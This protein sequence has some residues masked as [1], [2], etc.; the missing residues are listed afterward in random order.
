[1]TA[2]PQDTTHCA[3]GGGGGQS[4]DDA[5][6]ARGR[7]FRVNTRAD[8]TPRNL[9]R[10]RDGKRDAQQREDTRK[11]ETEMRI[12]ANMRQGLWYHSPC[13]HHSLSLL[14]FLC[15]SML[16]NGVPEC[17]HLA[18]CNLVQVVHISRPFHAL[19]L[20]DWTHPPPAGFSSRKTDSLSCDHQ[21]LSSAVDFCSRTDLSWYCGAVPA[22]SQPLTRV[23]FSPNG[24]PSSYSQQGRNSCCHCVPSYPVP[25][26]VNHSERADSPLAYFSPL[27]KPSTAAPT[28]SQSTRLGKKRPSVAVLPRPITFRLRWSSQGSPN[29]NLLFPCIAEVVVV[30][31]HPNGLGALV[32][33]VANVSDSGGVVGCPAD[34]LVRSLLRRWNHE[35]SCL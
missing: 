11:G 35:D 2:A 28:T 20:L 31:R 15:F 4:K 24:A 12:A 16:E 10:V 17:T 25:A 7:H 9:R 34:S 32:V 5:G 26:L 6:F 23:P 22:C 13:L 30:L 1:M 14:S 18:F 27:A 33:L 19:A 29:L 8:Y 3:D 21:T